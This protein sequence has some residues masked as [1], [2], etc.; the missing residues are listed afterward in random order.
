MTARPLFRF[1]QRVIAMPATKLMGFKGVLLCGTAG[2]TPGP[3]AKLKARDVS[4]KIDSVTDD[5]SDRDSIFE[6]VDVAQVKIGLQFELNNNTADTLASTVLAAVVSGDAVA[7]KTLDQASGKG[8]D[9][10]FVVSLSLEQPLKGAQRVKVDA[11][12]T[13]KAGRALTHNF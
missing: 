1:Q 4:Y 13:D 3:T 2:S 5:V 10:D 9:G 6:Y 8:I 12:P 7:L 11:M